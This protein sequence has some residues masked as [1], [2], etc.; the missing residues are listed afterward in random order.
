MRKPRPYAVMTIA[1]SDSC[2]GAGIQADLKTFC[3]LGLYGTSCI[4]AVTA[5]NTMEVRAV[6]PVSPDIVSSQIECVLDDFEVLA[7]KT[8]M[9]FCPKTIEAVQQSLKKKNYSGPLVV[10]PVLVATSG[11]TLAKA[12]LVQS[13]QTTLLPLADLLTPNIPEAEA[14]SGLTIGNKDEMISAARKI[15]NDFR[16]KNVLIKGGHLDSDQMTDILLT[17]DGQVQTFS[18]KKTD[19]DNT[20]GT[21]CTL[22]AAICSFLALGNDMSRAVSLAK[23]YIGSAIESAALLQMGHGHGSLNHAFAPRALQIRP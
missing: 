14:L 3:A 22:S 8:G 15:Q 17:K 10:D 13:L 6:S 23:T 2:G 4:S 19:S 9:L 5:Q 1:G 20:H 7:I 11:A 12:D 21:G 16:A 18:C